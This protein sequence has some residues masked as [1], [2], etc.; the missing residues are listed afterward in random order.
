MPDLFIHPAQLACVYQVNDQTRCM[1]P[2]RAS[3]VVQPMSKYLLFA[4]TWIK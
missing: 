2:K 3:M 1:M 4:N